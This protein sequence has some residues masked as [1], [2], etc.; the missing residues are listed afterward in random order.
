MDIPEEVGLGKK[1]LPNVV[2]AVTTCLLRTYVEV[3]QEC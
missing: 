3:L 2:C 1:A